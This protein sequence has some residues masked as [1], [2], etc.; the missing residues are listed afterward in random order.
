MKLLSGLRTEFAGFGVADVAL[1]AL[2]SLVGVLDVLFSP[3]WRGPKPANVV[4]VAA[5]GLVLVWRRRR[6]LLSLAGVLGGF[7]LLSLLFGSSQTSSSIFI[8]AVAVYSAA[9]YASNAPVTIVMLAAAVAIRDL[10]DPAISSVGESLWSSTFVLLTFLAGLAGR[11]LRQQ[12]RKVDER[13]R[14]LEREESELAAAAVA[15]ERRRIARELHDILSHNLS[16]LVLQAGAAEQ[17]LER[18]PASARRALRWIRETGQEAIG[19][20]NTLLGLVRGEPDASREPPASLGDIDKLVAK[21]SDMGIVVDLA[22]QG[23]QRRLP[24]GIELSAY[25]VV[26]EGLTNA[27]K[28]SSPSRARILLRYGEN[29]LVVEIQNDGLRTKNGHGSKRGLAGLRERIAIFGG[30]LEA[31]PDRD[32]GWVL[33]AVFP[34]EP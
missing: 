16:V 5:A 17:V 24:G 3:D 18:D 14:A 11:A 30:E 20:M 4:V 29:Q 19:E 9:V 12:R 10:N 23:E 1:A 8:G 25:R 26:Q 7:V 32:G 2:L 31:G 21:A 13:E 15:E 33:R 34:A 27:L 6:P 28:H 22:I